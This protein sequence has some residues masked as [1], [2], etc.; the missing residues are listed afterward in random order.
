MP[1]VLFP[2]FVP[3]EWAAL[4][5]FV[6]LA[7]LVELMGPWL[8][9]AASGCG[10]DLQA[11]TQAATM[12]MSPAVIQWRLQAGEEREGAGDG[13]MAGVCKWAAWLGGVVAVLCPVHAAR[14]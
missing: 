11:D 1:A 7:G 4:V 9:C 10:P 2:A 13:M 8:C 12:A 3:A 5:V 6:V 14:W